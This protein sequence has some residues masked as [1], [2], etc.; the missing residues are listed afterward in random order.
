MASESED[1]EAKCYL[2][3]SLNEIFCVRYYVYVRRF[4]DLKAQGLERLGGE[5]GEGEVIK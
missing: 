2:V 5:G 1:I 4:V 3:L